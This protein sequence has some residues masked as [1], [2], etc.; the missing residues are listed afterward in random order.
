MN[1]G[2]KWQCQVLDAHEWQEGSDSET[3]PISAGQHNQERNFPT[4]TCT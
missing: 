4:C 1:H 3:E 2:Q